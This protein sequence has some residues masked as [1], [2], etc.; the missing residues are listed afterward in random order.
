MCVDP[1]EQVDPT[2]VLPKLLL[3]LPGLV[4]VFL[5][6]VHKEKPPRAI[7]HLDSSYCH[8]QIDGVSQAR[9]A[10]QHENVGK[11]VIWIDRIKLRG[12]FSDI[13]CKVVRS[14][15]GTDL[16][17]NLARFEVIR[18]IEDPIIP[19]RFQLAVSDQ[20]AVLE[21]LEIGRLTTDA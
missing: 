15:I 4:P 5:V 20:F 3:L 13:P 12:G 10:D 19:R 14:R 7:R 16:L 21:E 6:W 9:M 2:G 1:K 11:L 8:V 18:N 17:T